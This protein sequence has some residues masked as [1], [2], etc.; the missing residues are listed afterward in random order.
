MD[1]VARRLTLVAAGV[2]SLAAAWAC[3]SSSNRPAELGSTGGDSGTHGGSSSGGGDA[4]APLAC[5][6]QDGGC[7]ALQNCGA[8]VYVTESTSTSPTPT[9]GVVPDGTYVL[10]TATLY[11]P[12]GVASTTGDW[13][14]E[15]IQILGTGS[16]DGGAE[17]GEA[18]EDSAVADDAGEAG[19]GAA[20]SDAGLT[21]AQWQEIDES[22]S[23]PAEATNTGTVTFTGTG[24]SITFLCPA[25]AAVFSAN[26]TYSPGSSSFL[27][28]T[29]FLTGNGMQGTTELTYLKQ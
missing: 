20:G 7:N 11:V 8:K 2:V 21:T 24:L 12:G 25:N 5:G 26:Y 16:G 19:V 23:N 14:R 29:P 28:Y 18:S 15:T 17:A 13:F 3:S 6:T 10:T 9:G 27:M 22:N 1:A 4:D